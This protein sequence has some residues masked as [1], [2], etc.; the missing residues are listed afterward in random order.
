[1]ENGNVTAETLSNQVG[2]SLRIPDA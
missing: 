1:S 2:L